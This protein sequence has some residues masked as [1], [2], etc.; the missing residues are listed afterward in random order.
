MFYHPPQATAEKTDTSVISTASQGATVS[1]H[2][3]TIP[4]KQ[5]VVWA[6]ENG[7]WQLRRHAE[8]NESHNAGT[9]ISCSWAT[10]LRRDGKTSGMS[11]TNI[12][13]DARLRILK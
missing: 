12:T 5:T 13:L 11:E 3:A 1:T 8:I 9:L 6:Y 2:S 7:D 4:S 10:L